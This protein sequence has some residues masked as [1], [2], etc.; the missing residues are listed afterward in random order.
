MQFRPSVARFALAWNSMREFFTTEDT[1]GTEVLRE[2]Y[3]D[4]TGR[5]VTKPK[6][7]RAFGLSRRWRDK[8]KNALCG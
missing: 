7:C 1:E 6:G 8:P 4:V 5:Y 3:Q 2:K